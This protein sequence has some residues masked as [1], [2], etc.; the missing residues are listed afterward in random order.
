MQGLRPSCEHTLY[1]PWFEH[2]ACGVGMVC[3]LQGEPSHDIVE[4]GLTILHRLD[5][6]GA[7][8]ADS[9]TGDGAGILMDLP[10]AFFRML[11][12]SFSLP[13]EGT[14]GAGLVFLPHA[15]EA[16]QRAR[17]VFSEKAQQL[18]LQLLG[19]REV[20]VH[21]ER[22]GEAARLAMP[23]IEQVFVARGKVSPEHFEAYLYLYRKAVE[24]EV[25]EVY[26]CSLSSRTIVY[27]GM[28]TVEQVPRFFEDLNHPTLAS[29]FALVHSRFS[30]NTLPEWSLAQPF[31]Y[32][33]HNGEI[34][35]LRG[36]INWMRAREALLHHPVWGKRIEVLHP[37]IR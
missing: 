24:Q 13:P 14:Y 22:I 32:L 10:D 25:P 28:L 21:P 36:N 17:S 15:S 27:K 7:R 23:V 16:R 8:G 31:R 3:C 20:P 29:R 1:D 30:T 9:E 34:N 33:C 2:D 11:N 6:R 19:W 12:L 26:I 37:I 35:T 4:M 18:G 5:H